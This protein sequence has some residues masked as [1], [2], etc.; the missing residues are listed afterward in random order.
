MLLEVTKHYLHIQNKYHIKTIYVQIKKRKDSYREECF[1]G[2]EE[3]KSSIDSI[4]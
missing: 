3:K 1:Y 2:L 4:F